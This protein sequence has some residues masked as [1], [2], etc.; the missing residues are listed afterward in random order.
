[1]PPEVAAALESAGLRWASVT[2]GASRYDPELGQ[3]ALLIA[4]ALS[5][6]QAVFPLI[7]AQRGSP[8]GCSWRIPPP[9]C[10][11]CSCSLRSRC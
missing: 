10:N 5:V 4:L 11:C 2:R 9:A 6:I 7:G 1:M 3:I 8:P